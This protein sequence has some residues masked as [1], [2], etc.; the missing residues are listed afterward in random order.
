MR[1]DF[2]G[3]LALKAYVYVKICNEIQK[4]G[5]Y[6]KIK[7]EKN[8]HKKFEMIQPWWSTYTTEIEKCSLGLHFLFLLSCVGLI[9][10]LYLFH[11]E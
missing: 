3:G 4:G 10:M 7:A 6:S 8:R 1:Q 2:G 5:K 9:R 11:F